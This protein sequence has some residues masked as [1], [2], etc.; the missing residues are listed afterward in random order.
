MAKNYYDILGVDKKASKDDI[1]KAFRK[2]AQKYH[3]DKGGDESKF[4][5]IT[6]A[7]A[8]LGDEKRRREYDTYGQAFPGGA[9]SGGPSGFPGGFDFSQFQQG[10]VNFDFGDIFAEFGDLFG[11]NAR[12]GRRMPRGRD[13]S[14]DIE[15]PFKDSI[16]GTQRSVLLAKVSQCEVCHGSGA[17]Q[18]TEMQT[19]KTC[20]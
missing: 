3:P 13:I 1:K 6:E 15:I 5:E 20:N 7:Y 2:L 17:K 12:G 16:L 14:I 11:A 4:K 18:G 9:P 19:C 10:D 8:V